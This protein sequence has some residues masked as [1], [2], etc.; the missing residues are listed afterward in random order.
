MCLT[1]AIGACFFAKNVRQFYE[2]PR[3]IF[4]LFLKC[5]NRNSRAKI[6]A[7]W[8][9]GVKLVGVVWDAG[10]LSIYQAPPFPLERNCSDTLRPARVATRIHRA[11][12]SAEPPLVGRRQ[13]VVAWTRVV[14]TVKSRIREGIDERHALHYMWGNAAS[15]PLGCKAPLGLRKCMLCGIVVV[16]VVEHPRLRGKSMEHLTNYRYYSVAACAR[17]L[18]T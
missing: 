5:R 17:F 9:G 16:C 7:T 18:K 11:T 2:L 12:W 10:P 13:A 4:V 6:A 3:G 1:G 14:A 8:Q 15:R